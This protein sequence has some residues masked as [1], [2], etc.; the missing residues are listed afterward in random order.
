MGEVRTD[1]LPALVFKALTT[2]EQLNFISHIAPGRIFKTDYRIPHF[3]LEDGGEVFSRNVDTYLQ[4]K[5]RRND[6]ENN[7]QFL[8]YYFLLK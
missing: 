1:R 4:A 6:D 8:F 3:K 2:L 7:I 5:T